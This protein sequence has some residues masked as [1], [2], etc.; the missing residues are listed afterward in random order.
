MPPARLP[1][2]HAASCRDCWMEGELKAFV[3]PCHSPA[4][5]GSCSPGARPGGRSCFIMAWQ[6]AQGRAAR[7]LGFIPEPQFCSCGEAGGQR[8][9]PGCSRE[10]GTGFTL[11][12]ALQN[13][14]PSPAWQAGPAPVLPSQFPELRAF[15]WPQL[16]RSTE[17]VML[18]QLH[19]MPSPCFLPTLSAHPCVPLPVLSPKPFCFQR[20]SFH[21][22][23]SPLCPINGKA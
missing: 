17:L 12:Q 14:S 1:S 19:P 11:L 18:H 22:P 13:C 15:P 7:Q 8:D 23:S 3:I 2:G 16:I 6:L 21:T 10:A 9:E 20:I 4:F 5:P